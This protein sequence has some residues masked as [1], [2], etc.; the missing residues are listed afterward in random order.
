MKRIVARCGY[1]CDL[2]LAYRENIK[3]TD[4]QA[5]FSD[6]LMK[7]YEYYLPIENCYCDGC[8]T[9]DSV[10]PQ[11]IDPGCEVRACVIKKKLEN[12]SFCEE[13]PCDILK[14]KFIHGEVVEKNFGK[15]VPQEDYDRFIKPYENKETLDKLRN[16]KRKK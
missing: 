11:L 13:Y 2:C 16:R 6:G 14:E 8:L 5:R 10:K 4:D 7:Y 3:N 9:D 12:C 15:P 1:R